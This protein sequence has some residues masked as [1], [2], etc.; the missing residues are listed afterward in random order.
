VR[1]WSDL[2]NQLRQAAKD[3]KLPRNRLPAPVDDIVT[4][5]LAGL[6]PHVG[7][8][9]PPPAPRFGQRRARRPLPQYIGP[10]GVRFALAPDSLLAQRPPAWLV[11]VELVETTRLWAH[12]AAPVTPEQVE[13][14]AGHLLRRTYHEIALDPASGL[15]RADERVWL[16]GLPLSERRVDYG[17]V[18]PAE[19]RAVFIQ[20][21]LVE[22]QWRPPPPAPYAAIRAHNLAVKA[23]IAAWQDKA[24]RLDLLVDDLTQADFFD[25]RLPPAVLSGP[26]LDRWLRRDPA[27]GD[28]LKASLA[29]LMWSESAAVDVDLYPDR[30]QVGSQ[31]L[32]LVYRFDPGGERDGVAVRVPAAGLA[33]LSA[34]PFSW[35]VPGQR[36]ELA[37]ALIRGLPKPIR[38]R[39]TPAGEMAG[40]ALDW[41][42]RHGYDQALPFTQ[43]LGRAL[44][45][46]TGVETG[47]WDWRT[48]PDH[49]KVAFLVEPAPPPGPKATAADRT[50]GRQSGK[51]GKGPA[52]G[53]AG[54]GDR[55]DRGQT[56]WSH[57]LAGLQA[58]AAP[59]LRRRLD[60][61]ER[62]PVTQGLSWV[63]GPIAE[64]V[65]LDLDG[66]GT[67]AYPGLRDDSSTVSQVLSPT[68]EEAGRLH[69]LGLVRLL[70]EALPDPTR[71]TVAHLTETD[72]LALASAPYDSWAALLAEARRASL[73]QLL[74][75]AGPAWSIRDQAAFAALVDRLRPTAPAQLGRLVKVAAEA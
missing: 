42:D 66:V 2:V 69:R 51:T 36:R 29:D 74:D 27:A 37:S 6:L 25:Q 28:R 17:R 70:L 44:E 39:L 48:V 53:A 35:G 46:L 22:D 61:L 21:G 47:S 59:R 58:A 55:D 68:L 31:D 11:A 41:L 18:A 71:W 1:E 62:G 8:L 49:L 56:V 54:A 34:A 57:D 26:S 24:R 52:S 32:P 30:W 12:Q 45:A 43:E 7:R 3:L 13:R 15:V 72:K 38:T 63:F 9:E 60:R 64:Q 19:A 75:Q 23:E 40:R 14:V 10:R 65:D 5:C 67:I 20:T 4:S 16:L 73:L 50:D 33:G